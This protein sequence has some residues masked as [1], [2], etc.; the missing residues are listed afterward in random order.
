MYT[1]MEDIIKSELFNTIDKCLIE[2]ELTMEQV[3]N[4]DN[5]RKYIKKIKNSE[6][7]IEF[8]EFI[9]YVIEH[10]KTF[11]VQISAIL[12]SNK[13]IKTDYY[14]FLND[15]ILFNN[16][17]HFKI[18]ENESK[19]TKK[20][21]IKYLYSIYMSCVFLKTGLGDENLSN[22]LS[23]FITS[24]KNNSEI[25][26]KE[27]DIKVKSVK[28]KSK[29][30]SKDATF[31]ELSKMLGN[32]GDGLNEMLGNNNLGGL[33]ESILGN[34]DILNIASDISQKMH[35]Q[36]L[37]PM[38][39]LTSLMSGDIENSPLQGLVKQIESGVQEKISSGEINKEELESQA[40]NIMNTIG[41][42][43]SALNSMSGMSDMLSNMMGEFGNKSS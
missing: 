31:N 22:K 42:N 6:N 23:E 11:E 36:N 24:V 18:F 41:S 25:G 30:K 40:K 38:T 32:G 10:L 2:I 21:L 34:K 33:M 26:L 43:P 3:K 7:V 15:I 28:N 14:K 5:I 16:M 12:F 20:D 9:E 4:V 1:C 19:N 29:N 17:L 39:M 8:N 27:S 35:N 13:K 37:N